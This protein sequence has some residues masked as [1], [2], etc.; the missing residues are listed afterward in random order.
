MED[1]GVEPPGTVRVLRVLPE[2]LHGLPLMVGAA[3]VEPATL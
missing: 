3:G 1:R 2:P